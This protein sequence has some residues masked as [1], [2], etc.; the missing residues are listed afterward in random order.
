[1]SCKVRILFS[2]EIYR[3]SYPNSC[4]TQKNETTMQTVKEHL[5]KLDEA[6]ARAKK[7]MVF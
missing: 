5:E 4:S 1:M 6:N 2:D 3:F 7:D